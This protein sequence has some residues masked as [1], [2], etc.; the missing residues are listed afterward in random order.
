MPEVS[1]KASSDRLDTF[2]DL[3]QQTVGRNVAINTGNYATN[4]GSISGGDDSEQVLH[5]VVGEDF[6]NE[7]GPSTEAVAELVAY[8]VDFDTMTI[9]GNSS[10]DVYGGFEADSNFGLQPGRPGSITNVYGGSGEDRDLEGDGT[11]E[12]NFKAQNFFQDRYLYRDRLRV[13]KTL[14]DT[15][16]GAGAGGHIQDRTAK[17]EV[18][19]LRRHFGRGPLVTEDDALTYNAQYYKYGTLTDQ[20]GHKSGVTLWWDIYERDIPEIQDILRG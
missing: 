10:N 14:L 11:A 6:W 17:T 19:N 13:Q 18:T 8:R 3:I 5:E 16:N 2:D 20:V 4:A 15:T 7:L 9:H 12:S 1:V